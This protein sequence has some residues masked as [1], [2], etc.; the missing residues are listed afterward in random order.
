MPRR[1][2][3]HPPQLFFSWK[4]S[5]YCRLVFPQPSTKAQESKLPELDDFLSARDYKGAIMLLEFQKKPDSEVTEEDSEH[6]LWL[7]YAYFHYGEHD[8]ALKVYK[9]LLEMSNEN[10]S[11]YSTYIA[12]CL[13]YVGKYEEAEA[14]ALDGPASRLRTRLLFHIANKQNDE[15]KLMEYH[16]QLTDSIEDQLSL[17]AMHFLRTHYNEATDIYKKLLLD[18]RDFVAL[19]VYIALCYSKL[20]YYDVSLEILSVYLQAF[21][22][23]SFAVN[24]K[25]CNQFKLFNGRSAEQELKV[26][27]EHGKS[28]ME[29]SLIKHNACVF[30]GGEN[31]MQ[32]LPKLIDLIP[33]ARLNMVVYH[34]RSGSVE[35]AINLVSSIEP[36]NPQEYILKAIVN[37]IVGQDAQN[38]DQI[39]VAQH[40]FNLVGGSAS[41]CDTIPGRQCMASSYFLLKQFEDVL[42]YLKSIKSYL[43]SDDRFNWNF[44]IALAANGDFEEAEEALLQVQDESFKEDYCYL[45][46]LAKTYVANK[47]ARLAWELYLRV[48]SSDDSF[49]LLQLIANECYSAGAYYFSAKAF[50]VLERLDPNPD[51]WDGKRGACI[52]VFKNIVEGKESRELLKDIK[53]ML[54][55]TSNPQ[56]EYI[57]RTITKWEQGSAGF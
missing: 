22:D 23:S 17:A 57:I 35:E 31:S 34:L 36:G 26:L 48:E 15:T 18:N 3:N 9:G 40:N 32:V 24:L 50:D 16:Q 10:C 4:T 11:V 28:L 8:K 46:W 41:E 7:A 38:Q 37:A 19:N 6:L 55:Y 47:K 20:D 53:S 1:L 56:V 49:N 51:Y 25:A 14:Y 44:G 30:R 5:W 12:A 43:S 33:E 29:D 54:R 39:G 21:P 2:T 42:V 45:S 27:Q 52:G 13:Y